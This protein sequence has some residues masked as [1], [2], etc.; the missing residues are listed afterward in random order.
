MGKQWE[1]VGE[2]KKWKFREAI[3]WRI[4]SIKALH[5]AVLRLL[6]AKFKTSF[7]LRFEFGRRI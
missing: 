5:V 1:V 7:A 2:R 3:A 4:P 6:S